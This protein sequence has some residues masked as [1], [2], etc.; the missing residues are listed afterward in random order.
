MYVIHQQVQNSQICE[1]RTAVG[2][3]RACPRRTTLTLGEP[4]TQ[5]GLSVTKKCSPSQR[6]QRMQTDIDY[7]LD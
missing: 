2:H 3:C 1:Q 6:N 5:D 7:G 4:G